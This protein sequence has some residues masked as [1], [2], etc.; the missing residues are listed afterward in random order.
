[1]ITGIFIACYFY[2]NRPKSIPFLISHRGP[3]DI[4]AENVSIKKETLKDVILM[5]VQDPENFD[6]WTK[7]RNAYLVW[8]PTDSGKSTTR[9]YLDE[10]KKRDPTAILGYYGTFAFLDS[11][12]PFLGGELVTIAHVDSEGKEDRYQQVRVDAVV[13]R[14]PKSFLESIQ[15]SKAPAKGG[16]DGM[17]TP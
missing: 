15:S 13:M 16:N 12:V 14:P 2:I 17:R 3:P 1:M 4:L 11:R 8:L 7:I 10:L 5:G 6:D 9:I